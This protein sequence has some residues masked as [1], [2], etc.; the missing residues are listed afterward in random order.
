[1]VHMALRMAWMFVLGILCAAG[2][3][4]VSGAV[5][6]SCIIPHVLKD[7][8]T[9]Q[10]YDPDVS[11]NYVC[12]PN[13]RQFGDDC[14]HPVEYGQHYRPVVVVSFATAQQTCQ[15]QGAEVV[16]LLDLRDPDV[17]QAVVEIPKE[18]ILRDL[19]MFD[20]S[21]CV[22][23]SDSSSVWGEQLCVKRCSEALQKMIICRRPADPVQN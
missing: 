22:E 10:P 12:P 7:R 2:A 9:L 18:H 19:L 13:Y 11:A 16:S 15:E 21:S 20:Q 17:L 8:D 23:R 4:D 5:I 14:F 6:R 3:R 1:M